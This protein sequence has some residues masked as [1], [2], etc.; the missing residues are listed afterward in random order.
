VLAGAVHRQGA[1]L[2]AGPDG[3]GLGVVVE[4]VVR[5]RLQRVHVEVAQRE[6]PADAV[7]VERLAAVRRAGQRKQ[8]GWQVE[9]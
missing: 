4:R 5:R 6:D 9:A 2:L 1:G 7:E 3:R 8:V